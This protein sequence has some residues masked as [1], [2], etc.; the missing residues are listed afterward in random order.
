[1]EYVP[2][3][4]PDAFSRS[5]C[6]SKSFLRSVSSWLVYSLHQIKGL[7]GLAR[8]YGVFLAVNDIELQP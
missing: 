4:A 7:T 6:R 8:Q 1:M 2:G 5:G 3:M